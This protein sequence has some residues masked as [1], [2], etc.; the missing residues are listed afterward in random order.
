VPDAHDAL[1]ARI[2]A[3]SQQ[4]PSGKPAVTISVECSEADRGA[5]STFGWHEGLQ[6]VGVL[7]IDDGSRDRGSGPAAGL[8]RDGGG[9]EI[10]LD[11]ESGP[12]AIYDGFDLPLALDW[13]AAEGEVA[14]E[15]GWS[16]F[17]RA[18]F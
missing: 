14:E 6:T 1:Q 2:G 17:E 5:S 16:Q 9:S 15:E 10:C 7:G 8:R 3:Q 12:S 13:N 11:A 4:R 18:C